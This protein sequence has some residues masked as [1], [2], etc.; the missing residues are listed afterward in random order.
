LPLHVAVLGA[1]APLQLVQRW[2]ARAT[3]G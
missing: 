3:S 1:V 2:F